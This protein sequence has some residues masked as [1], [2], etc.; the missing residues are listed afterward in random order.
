MVSGLKLN[1]ARRT[2]SEIYFSVFFFSSQSVGIVALP[3]NREP[4]QR[5]RLGLCVLVSMIKRS[6]LRIDNELEVHE[7]WS[8]GG[9]KKLF[10]LPT[11]NAFSWNFRIKVISVVGGKV[12]FGRAETCL[13]SLSAEK[14]LS[15]QIASNA[16]VMSH[17]RSRVWRREM[18]KKLSDNYPRLAPRDERA[19]STSFPQTK[20]HR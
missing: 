1:C 18:K 13:C 15:R 4:Y 8:I 5:D 11:R 17:F 12:D 9:I 7:N 20:Q 6:C 2:S 16:W 10:L 3:S 19:R 14:Q